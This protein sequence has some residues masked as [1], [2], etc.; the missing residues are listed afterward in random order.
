MEKE[1]NFKKALRKIV[2]DELKDNLGLA[3]DIISK[4]NR[5]FD[6]FIKR[7]KAKSKKGWEGYK[8]LVHIDDIL[9]LVGDKLNDRRI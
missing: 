9:K 7:L 4:V 6:E 5:K 1:F 3:D 8:G 2:E